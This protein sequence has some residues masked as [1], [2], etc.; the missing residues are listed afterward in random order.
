MNSPIRN[1]IVSATFIASA[2]VFASATYDNLNDL[3]AEELL[4]LI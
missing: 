2:V 1:Y 3:Y 4:E